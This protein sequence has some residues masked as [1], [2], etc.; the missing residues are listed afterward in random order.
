MKLANVKTAASVALHRAGLNIKK[1]SPEILLATGVISIIGGTVLA[2]KATLKAE[3]VLSEHEHD[4]ES[5]EKATEVADEVDYTPEMRKKDLILVYTQTAFKFTKLYAPAGVLIIGG[6]AC[7]MA[8][9]G[10]MKKRQA[11]LMTAYTAL[12]TAFK[13]YRKRVK[14]LIGDEEE[15]KLYLN[16]DDVKKELFTNPETGETKEMTTVE[17]QRVQFSPYAKCFDEKS[18]MW[19]RNANTNLTTLLF[20][21][22]Q[23]NDLLNIRGHVFLNEVYDALDIPH[24]QEG[25]LVGWVKG[26]GVG[27]DYIDFGIY[28]IKSEAARDFVNGYEYSIWLDFN[29]QGPIYNLI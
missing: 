23:M 2:C 13:D 27:D 4:M 16:A 3:E 21:Q 15:E 28:N 7:I 22:N 19:K 5:I 8:S 6:I 11:A 24:T 18:C 25:A 14:N 20:L 17:G 1:A 26:S 10:I 12:D 29:V 9:H